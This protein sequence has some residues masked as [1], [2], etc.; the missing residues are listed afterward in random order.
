VVGAADC[1]GRDPELAGSPGDP[2]HRQRGGAVAEAAAGVDHADGT[3][4]PDQLGG[5]PRHQGAAVGLR[6]VLRDA[7]H[8]VGVVAG[9]VGAD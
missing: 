4:L 2:L 8:A 7:E 9:Q 6:H 5:R 3:R 1:G